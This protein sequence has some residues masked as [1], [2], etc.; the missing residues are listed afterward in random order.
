[1]IETALAGVEA[2]VLLTFTI[3]SVILAVCAFWPSRQDAG[4]CDD[5]HRAL[6]RSM[7]E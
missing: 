2:A 1:M 7:V 6:L 5:D 4:K 3:V